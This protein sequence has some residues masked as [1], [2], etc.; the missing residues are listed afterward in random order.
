ML[1]LWGAGDTGRDGAGWGGVSNVGWWVQDLEGQCQG[2]RQ[3][4]EKMGEQES[5]P[6]QEKTGREQWMMLLS[7]MVR[8]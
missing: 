8:C 5:S 7:T 4:L 1:L 2:C 6:P 3:Q